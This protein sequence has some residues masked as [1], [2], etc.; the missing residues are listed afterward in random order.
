M[1]GSEDDNPNDPGQ[2][3]DD[4]DDA[5]DE[6]VTPE[7][8]DLELIKIVNDPTPNIGDFV[9]F[10]I[11]VTNNGP[12]DATGVMVGDALPNGYGE[13][14]NISNGGATTANGL[15]WSDLSIA[16]GETLSLTFDAEVLAP[17]EGVEYDN[18]SQ[19]MDADQFDPDSTP[20]NGPDTDGDGL[21]GPIDDN[22]NDQSVDPDDEDDGDN[23]PVE[24][25]LLSI[26][27]NVFVDNDNDG[28]RDDDEPG[29]EG[30]TV[31]IFNTGADGIAENG[32]DELVGE[33]VTDANGDY[34]VDG[35]IPGDYY[36]SISDVILISQQVVD[37]QA[38][39]LTMMLITMITVSR[40]LSVM[41]YGL[42]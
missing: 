10:T 2:D 6:P 4:E 12:S 9:T 28:I 40:M 30:L 17:G 14:T 26:G 13:V 24:P 34:F 19:V 29:I 18:L 38:W 8:A 11:E 31:Q 5:D 15:A 16:S 36:A 42:T 21:V 7:V 33:D 27:S 3:P 35:L 1:I 23:E 41:E 22:P 39:I 37:L 25:L 32:D 20:G